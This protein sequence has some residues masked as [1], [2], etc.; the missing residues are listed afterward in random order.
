MV[1]QLPQCTGAREREPDP[2]FSQIP[3]LLI[4]VSHTQS[5][6]RRALLLYVCVRSVA[7]LQCA[8]ALFGWSV[9]VS[10]SCTAVQAT[11]LRLRCSASRPSNRRLTFTFFDT[12]FLVFA[13]TTSSTISSGS[14]MVAMS[15]ARRHL[16]PRRCADTA[17][18]RSPC[19]RSRKPGIPP[20][21]R[22]HFSSFPLACR[23]GPPTSAA[24]L[25]AAPTASTST[26]GTVAGAVAE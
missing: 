26:S 22:G 17:P 25:Q 11:R 3:A 5:H 21:L 13:R 18:T 24:S 9:P 1:A 12:A 4:I 19:C 10:P 20:P 14:T 6:A 2:T 8:V 15:C 16:S 23:V 7:H